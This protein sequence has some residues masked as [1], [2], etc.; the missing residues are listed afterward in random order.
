MTKNKKPL[1]TVIMS[2]YNT[3]ESLFYESVKSILEQSY[4]NIEL[5]IIDDDGVNDANKTISAFNDSRIKIIKNHK[6]KG[7][8]YSLNKAL[9]NASGKYIARMDTDDYSYPDRI[10]KQVAY[11]ESNPIIDVVGTGADLFDGNK[12]WGSLSHEGLITR[13][14]I[15]SSSPF[16]HP[17]IMA[18]KE[19][20]LKA[21]G[22]PDFRRCED[23]ALWITLYAK[24][25]KMANIPEHLLRYH[26][27]LNDYKKRTIRTRK[28]FFRMIRIHYVPL[29][30]PSIFQVVKIY[31]RN[32]VAGIIPGKLAFEIQK[33][34]YGNTTYEK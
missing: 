3:P 25:C 14:Q 28:D 34:K 13:T 4:K 17:T 10:K 9:N 5:I 24:G 19:V 27:S 15:L 33:R 16:I 23:Y 7:L 22:Y 31:L 2:E 6:N 11:L 1:V 21:G 29:L 12:I 26:L 18:K 8:V 32:I 30:K 20:L